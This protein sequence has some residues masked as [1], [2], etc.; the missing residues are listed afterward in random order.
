MTTDWTV[1]AIMRATIPVL[2]ALTILEIGSGLV[3]N[4][5][6]ATLLQYPTLL[7]LV[8]VVIGTAGNLGS[9]L[10]SRLSTAL[11]LGTLSFG[12]DALLVGNALATVALAFTVF[13]G[14][15]IGAWLLTTLLGTAQLPIMTILLVAVGSGGALAVIAVLVTVVATYTAYRLQLDPDDVVIPVVTNVCDVFGVLVLFAVVELIV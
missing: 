5:F 1:R 4:E 12:T 2:F 10:A 6:E 15:G 9:I 7:V 13:P 11:H 8:P 3:L 14:V